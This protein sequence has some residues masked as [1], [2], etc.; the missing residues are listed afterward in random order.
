MSENGREGPGSEWASSDS[1]LAG[2][3]TEDHGGSPRPDAILP[4]LDEG[5]LADLRAVGREWEKVT[6]EPRLWREALPVDPAVGAYT[7]NA[8][9]QPA[10]FTRVVSMAG[11]TGRAGSGRGRQAARASSR[12]NCRRSGPPVSPSTAPSQPRNDPQSLPLL[13]LRHSPARDRPA[14]AWLQVMASTLTVTIGRAG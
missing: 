7:G 5:Q 4:A 9:F 8:A 12:E 6:A 1:R 11:G 3:A 10:R 14:G 13:P 2:G